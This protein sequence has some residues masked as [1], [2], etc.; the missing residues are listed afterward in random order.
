MLDG[1]AFGD[2]VR[3]DERVAHAL[4]FTGV[5][6]FLIDE[7]YGIP[8]AQEP[9]VFLTMLRRAWDEAQPDPS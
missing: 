4:G 3:S 2:D 7:T 5:P 1:D 9:D 8:G 6:F